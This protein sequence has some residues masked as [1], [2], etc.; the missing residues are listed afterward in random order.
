MDKIFSQR[1]PGSCYFWNLNSAP[2]RACCIYLYLNIS[3]VNKYGNK[4]GG[5]TLQTASFLNLVLKQ[6]VLFPTGFMPRSQ[7]CMQNCTTAR[8]RRWQ[9]RWW[10]LRSSRGCSRSGWMLS[11]ATRPWRTHKVGIWLLCRHIWWWW[12]LARWPLLSSLPLLTSHCPALRSGYE[13]EEADLPNLEDLQGAAKGLMRL[14]DVYC[15]QVS[16]LV[17]G[18]FQKVADGKSV[19]IHLP[20]VS[21]QLS[22]DDCFLVGKVHFKM[23][24]IAP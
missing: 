22:G 12:V 17:R 3:N 14:Q 4:I 5:L 21:V 15:L 7:A 23:F 6:T 1:F 24:R 18:Q 13:E 2:S 16:S 8:Q 10:R 20:A 19:D 9:T 11:T